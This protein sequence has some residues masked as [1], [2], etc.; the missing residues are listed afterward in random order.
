VFLLE[1]WCTFFFVMVILCQIHTNTQESK[2]GV[3]QAA[4]IAFTLLAM[5][6]TAGSISGGCFNPAFGLTQTTYQV[7][8]MKSQGVEEAHRYARF[9]WVYIIAPTLGGLASSLFMR[10]VHIP[11]LHK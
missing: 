7:G 9:L 6:E 10:F 3:L 5:I 11:N 1:F 4:A 8:Y 2:D